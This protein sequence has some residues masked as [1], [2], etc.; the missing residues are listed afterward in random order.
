VSEVCPLIFEPILKPKVWGGRALADLLGRTLPEGQSIGESWECADLANGQSV[1]ARGPQRGRTLH[2]IVEEWGKAL[3]GRARLAAGR[4]PLLIKY[5]DAC[6]ALSIQVHP[7][8]ATHAG[9]VAKNE[10][11]FVLSA[12]PDSR[13]YRGLAK[14]VGTQDLRAAIEKGGDALLACLQSTPAKPGDVFYVPAGTVHAIGAGVVVAEVQAPS[15]VT[16]RLFDWDRVRPASDQGLH[17]EEGLACIGGLN[18]WAAAEKRSHVSSVFTTVTRLV[19]SPSFMIEKVRFVEDIEQDIPYAEL[20]CW[21]VL[22]GRGEIRHGRGTVE[23]FTKGEVVVLPA[24]LA[25]GRLKT[26]AACS[27]LEVTLPAKSDLAEFEKPDAA[28]LRD[29]PKQANAPIPLNIDRRPKA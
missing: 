25:K 22:E 17:V 15:D 10:A 27:V 23:T 3:I 1:V 24:E 13:I 28:M 19:T 20:V 16:Y 14:G 4:F 9:G 8:D 11:W 5:L 21:I 26:L 12:K 18:D 7:F 2:D 29:A 6:E